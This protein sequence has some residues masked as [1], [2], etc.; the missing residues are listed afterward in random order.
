LITLGKKKN[1]VTARG[2][3]GRLGMA[4]QSQKAL[5][6][7]IRKKRSMKEKILAK[8]ERKRKEGPWP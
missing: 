1:V 5:T 3:A 7:G 2:C 6:T 8:G 4:G